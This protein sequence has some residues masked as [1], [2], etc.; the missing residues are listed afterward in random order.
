MKKL[1]SVIVSK[2]GKGDRFPASTIF[3][4]ERAFV[5]ALADFYELEDLELLAGELASLFVRLKGIEL[6]EKEMW[7]QW[8]AQGNG[9]KSKLRN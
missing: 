6:Q 9:N 1:R 3:R 7:R 8:E 2:S 4:G 5:E